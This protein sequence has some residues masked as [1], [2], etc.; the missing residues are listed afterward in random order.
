LARFSDI[1]SQAVVWLAEG[2]LCSI[3]RRTVEPARRL[4]IYSVASED[5]AQAGW[6]LTRG[7]ALRRVGKMRLGRI[8]FEPLQAESLNEICLPDVA[9][10]L[11][12]LSLHLG[13]GSRPTR[14]AAA[15]GG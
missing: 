2:N 15:A 5:V 4:Q 11:V 12:V 13:G 10:G 7:F 8:G 1:F 14:C 6:L 3:S 9:H